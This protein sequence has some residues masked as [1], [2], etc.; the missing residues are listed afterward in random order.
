MQYIQFIIIFCTVNCIL[1]QR[2][3]KF[4][5]TLHSTSA[6]L[7]DIWQTTFTYNC[8]LFSDTKNSTLQA[9]VL[10]SNTVLCLHD[11]QPASNCSIHYGANPSNLLNTDTAIADGIIMLT[12]NLTGNTT[13]YMVFTTI[14]SLTVKLHGYFKICSIQDLMVLTVTVQPQSSCGEPSGDSPIACYNGM[15]PGS[16]V[17]YHC[18]NSTFVSPSD[19]STR[20][21]QS[22]GMWSGTTPRCICNGEIFLQLPLSSK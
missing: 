1:P 21:C 4:T 7:Y 2:N 3:L 8:V 13:F 19:Q 11:E 17:V 14:G 6:I 18:A 9:T 12:S 10:S 15:T 5:S 22:N 16:T 20:T